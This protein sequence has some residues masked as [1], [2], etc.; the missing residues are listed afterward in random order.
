MFNMRSALDCSSFLLSASSRCFCSCMSSI[1]AWGRSF[2]VNLLQ[3]NFHFFDFLLLVLFHY[4]P[5]LSFVFSVSRQGSLEFSVSH[6]RR[7]GTIFFLSFCAVSST[8][9][10]FS[11]ISSSAFSALLN[12]VSI[13]LAFSS[14]RIFALN[15]SLKSVFT[16]RRD[17][18]CN[19]YRK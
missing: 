4:L 11:V 17:F 10:S 14:F 9:A 16:W 13:Q 2:L 5:H 12:S 6:F 8:K 1:S 18:T 7:F 3:C 19:S 15:L